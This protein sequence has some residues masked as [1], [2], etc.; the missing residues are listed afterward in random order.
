MTGVEAR[1]IIPNGQ[2]VWVR[3]VNG[4]EAPG[5]LVSWVNRNGT[6]R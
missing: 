5:L 4:S 3:Q 1:R 2:H 6:C